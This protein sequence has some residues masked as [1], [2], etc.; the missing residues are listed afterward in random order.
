MM[1]LLPGRHQLG[2]RLLLSYLII[3][4]VSVVVLF[5]AAELVVPGVLARHA[6]RMQ[7]EIG[8]VA[9]LEASLSENLGSAINEILGVAASA[10]TLAAIAVSIF[11]ARRIVGPVRAMTRASQRI[12]DGDYRQ[13]IEIPSED[14]LG[15]LARTF[16]QMAETLEQSERRRMELIGNVAHELRTPLTSIRS[17]M[18][19]LMDGVLPA[20]PDTYEGV[21]R[22]VA[23]L[24][25][26]VRDLEELSRAEAHQI[27]LDL[28]PVP[29][30]GLVRTATERL[31]PQ[32]EDKGV[33]LD[34]NI[35]A[36]LPAVRADAG[37]IMQVLINLLGN[38]L[39][40]TPAGGRVVVRAWTDGG[41][42]V[43][44]VQDSGIGIAAEDLPHLFERFYR[45][46]K[47]RSRSGGG[48]GIGL[49][50]SKHL[51]EAHGGRIWAASDGLGHGSSF[52]FTLPLAS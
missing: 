40:Y 44:S 9:N 20:E 31:A 18:E 29:P 27:P 35:P 51:V 37:R 34:T 49:T 45:V 13:R 52:S 28:R 2:W 36:G 26:L 48:S 47:S 7:L 33:T 11:T 3:V 5:G 38:A 32:F 23:R 46:D 4:G 21:Q 41:D 24:Q 14:E 1:S 12:A 16:N 25:R 17:V 15:T 30:A 8:D 42:A 39:Q 19:G 43:F 10:A 6:A 50:I 22:E